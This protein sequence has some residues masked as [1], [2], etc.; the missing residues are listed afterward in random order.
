MKNIKSVGF[1]SVAII[2]FMSSYV[3]AAEEMIPHSGIASRLTQKESFVSPFQVI[4]HKSGRLT[5]EPKLIFTEGTQGS[6]FELP[7]LLTNPEPMSLPDWILSQK[8][9]REVVLAV[10]VKIDGTVSE[11]MVM[12][13]SGNE[14]L[15]HWARELV[16]NWQFRPAMKNGKAVYECIQ[17]PIL[18][19]PEPVE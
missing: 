17:I 5:I 4:V 13:P 1:I 9:G 8:E 15:D 16:H 2:L 10:A 14:T 3:R 11:T 12:K 6:Q 19:K 7:Q 18:F